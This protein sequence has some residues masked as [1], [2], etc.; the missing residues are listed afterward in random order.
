MTDFNADSPPASRPFEVL[1][2]SESSDSESL[3]AVGPGVTVGEGSLVVV[4]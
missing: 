3:E 1:V 4:W 2:E